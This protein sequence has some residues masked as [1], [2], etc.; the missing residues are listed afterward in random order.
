MNSAWNEL[1]GTDVGLL[2]LGV[3]IGILVIAA[4]FFTVVLR[5]MR[6]GS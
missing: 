6:A 3:I 1:L 5:K 2:S 4:V